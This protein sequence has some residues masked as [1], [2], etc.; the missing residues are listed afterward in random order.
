M[1]EAFIVATDALLLSQVPPEVALLNVIE[2]PTHTELAPVIAATVELIVLQLPTAPS[3]KF[4]Y[5]PVR[6]KLVSVPQLLFPL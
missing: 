6:L 3:T 4:E 1:P 5:V 2:L